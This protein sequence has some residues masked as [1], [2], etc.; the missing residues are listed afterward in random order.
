MQEI[1]ERLREESI[2]TL[3][4][5]ISNYN[6]IFL[7]NSALNSL[8][9][10][11]GIELKKFIKRYEY[12]KDQN[13][14]VTF[15]VK[16]FNILNFY[17][18]ILMFEEIQSAANNHFPYKEII[19]KSG[20]KI[21][22]IGLENNRLIRDTIKKRKRFLDRL[23]NE[24]RVFSFN[25]VEKNLYKEL[26]NNYLNIQ[27]YHGLSESDYD[28]LISGTVVSLKKGTTALLSN[29]FHI[30]YAWKIIL[31]DRKISNEQL[32]FFI[33]KKYLNFERGF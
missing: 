8:E 10:G 29:D 11:K 13:D 7:D 30:L 21:S 18:P 17:L 26:Y 12:Y 19:K 4:S 15:L 14:F 27:K 6:F 2:E 16:N 32:G 23:K 28:F 20:G 3:D 1:K 31:E 24:E 22:R 25:G 5:I 9:L 33:R